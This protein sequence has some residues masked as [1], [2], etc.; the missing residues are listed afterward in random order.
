MP[1][2]ILASVGLLMLVGSWIIT[3]EWAIA[4]WYGYP[5]KDGWLAVLLIGAYAMEWPSP[6]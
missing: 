2:L 4:W 1:K 6:F 5:P 3:V